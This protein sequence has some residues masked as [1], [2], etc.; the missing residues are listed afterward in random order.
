MVI[1]IIINVQLILSSSAGT[2]AIKIPAHTKQVASKCQESPKD[3]N[4]IETTKF[5][6]ICASKLGYFNDNTNTPH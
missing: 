3:T 6:T 1:I 5:T 4:I 2:T